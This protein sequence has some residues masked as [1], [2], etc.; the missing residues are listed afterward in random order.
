MNAPLYQP[1]RAHNN[2][3]NMIPMINIVVLLLIFFMLAGQIQGYQAKDMRLPDA[4]SITNS[5]YKE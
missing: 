2:D 1:Q 5:R 3:A 4:L